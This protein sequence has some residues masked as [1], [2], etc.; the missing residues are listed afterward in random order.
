MQIVSLINVPCGAYLDH[1]YAE[2]LASTSFTGICRDF[3]N[4]RDLRA[5][6]GKFLWQK[7]CCLESFPFFWL[8]TTTISNEIFS[9][10]FLIDY[11]H[12]WSRSLISKALPTIP[13]SFSTRATDTVVILNFFSGRRTG[14]GRS[15]G[16]RALYKHALACP[17][18]RVPLAPNLVVEYVVIK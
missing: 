7:S 10:K 3:E 13:P 4:W 1:S 5:L 14:V 6:S 12:S 11:I 15:V 17:C 16:L 9:L 8:C 18:C 2:D